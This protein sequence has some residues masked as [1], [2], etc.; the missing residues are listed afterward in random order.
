MPRIF[1]LK[2][3]L[4]FGKNGNENGTILLTGEKS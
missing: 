1:V 4:F 2:D 3:R